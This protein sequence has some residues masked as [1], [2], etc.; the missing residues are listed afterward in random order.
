M[1]KSLHTMANLFAQLGEANDTAAISRFIEAH[2]AMPG[3]VQ[4]HE[5]EFW[6]PSQASF[7]RAAITD[8]AD[9]AEVADSLNVALHAP[10]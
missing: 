3:E 6:T 7:L 2:R 1:E 8:D 9:W 4:L 10:N 5:A